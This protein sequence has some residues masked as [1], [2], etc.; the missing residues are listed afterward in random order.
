[1]VLPAVAGVAASMTRIA[2]VA[3]PVVAI[4]AVAGVGA[5]RV[6]A[7]VVAAAIAAIA[8]VG[9]AVIA[10]GE[11]ALAGLTGHLG[12]GAR[13]RRA[14]LVDA[15][16]DDRALRAI[17]RL[18]GALGQPSLCDHA[19]ALRQAGGDVGRQR[20]GA[21]VPRRAVHEQ[22]V[23]VLPLVR[24]AVERAGGRGD[25]EIHHRRAARNG[26]Q[27]GVASEVADHGDNRFA[28]HGVP[29]LAVRAACR[30][31]R[32]CQAVHSA[33]RRRLAQR[34]DSLELCGFA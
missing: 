17:L 1:M 25:G 24:V 34:H 30:R 14:D 32:M 31:L 21:T 19:H 6:A 5:T 11:S 27:L 23:A 20:G 28:C 7:T 29:S 12:G 15:K 13:Q 10:T 16:L 2:A 8:G 4:A 9:A 22:R 3:V 33:A 26:A 18:I